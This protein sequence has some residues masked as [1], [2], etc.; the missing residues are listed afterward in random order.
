MTWSLE[1]SACVPIRTRNAD[2]LPGV[3]DVCGSPYLV[4]YDVLPTPEAKSLLRRQR[5]TMWRYGPWLPLAEGEHPVTLG[6]G[7]TPL[8]PARRLGA[9][10]GFEQLWV[11]DESTNP[12]GSFKAR[13]L[14][15]AVTRAVRAG[16]EQFVVPT[17]GNAGVAL[18]AYATRAGVRARIYAPANTPAPIL[19]QV[20]AFGGDLQLVDGHIGDCG[21]AAR[22][23]SD[24]TGAVDVS[25]LREP[26]R[27]EGKKTLGLEL[28]EQLGWTLPDAIVYPTG[29]GT[30]LI[31]M[32]KAFQE[33]RDS[34]WIRGPLPRMYT[35]QATGCAP[36]VEAFESGAERATACPDPKTVAAGLRVPSP[37]GD[38]LMLRA[39]RDSKGGAVA[40]SDEA[41]L[42]AANEL[43][44]SEGIDASPE[45]GAALAGA[46][47]LKR[48]GQ[49]SGT[50]RVV[51]FNTGA[52]WLYR[53]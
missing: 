26:Y 11:K 29:G 15:A 8:L 3:C 20:R 38:R 19:A 37:L 2:G 46:V 47:E 5:W 22:L 4:R 21:I 53:A 24:N 40:V 28:A 9:R 17:A 16:A 51:L 23:H 25:T 7:G 18:A 43:Q 50:E 41:L 48:R 14:A 1:C 31:G 32:W 12:T 33:L 52:G 39:L 30:G 27:I 49:L 10:H 34:G 6:E 44:T 45:G 42:A 35:V 36:V 13:G